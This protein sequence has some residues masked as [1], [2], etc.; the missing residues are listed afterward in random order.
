MTTLKKQ[1]AKIGARKTL[2]CAAKLPDKYIIKDRAVF[3]REM[4]SGFLRKLRERKGLS[5]KTVSTAC[6]VSPVVYRMFEEGKYSPDNHS[7]LR[8]VA[9]FYGLDYEN[10]RRMLEYK[11]SRRSII[12]PWRDKPGK[13]RE[14]TARTT[15]KKSLPAMAM[16]GEND[17]ESE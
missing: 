3:L 10:L 12:T 15:G 1:S 4:R 7:S 5:V 17:A 8:S 9:S 6:G 14:R 2:L 11:S 13:I 16:G